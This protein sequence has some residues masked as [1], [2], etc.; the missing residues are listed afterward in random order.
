[1]AKKKVKRA[2]KPMSSVRAGK[3]PVVKSSKDSSMKIVLKNFV[4][5]LTLFIVAVILGFVFTN[6]MLNNLFWI[7]SILTGFVAVALLLIMLILF[8][9]RAFKK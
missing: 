7:L 6:E 9:L 3:R 8:F 5:F 2:V 4:F 1:M